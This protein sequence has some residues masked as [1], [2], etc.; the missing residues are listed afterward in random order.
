MPVCM[1]SC[2]YCIDT[3]MC[4]F[5]VIICYPVET[6][7]CVTVSKVK[8]SFILVPCRYFFKA[9]CHYSMS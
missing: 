7:C 1:N 2:V 6:T 3:C 8:V 5:Y 9:S 4:V